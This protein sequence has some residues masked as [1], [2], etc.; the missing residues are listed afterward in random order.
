[1]PIGVTGA[2]PV[3]PRWGIKGQEMEANQGR[4]RE[5]RELDGEFASLAPLS[6]AT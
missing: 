2:A 4:D 3:T 5:E 6:V 1:M